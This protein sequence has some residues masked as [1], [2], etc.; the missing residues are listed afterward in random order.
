MSKDLAFLDLESPG[1]L[2]ALVERA[3]RVKPQLLRAYDRYVLRRYDIGKEMRF[4]LEDEMNEREALNLSLHCTPGYAEFQKAPSYSVLKVFLSKMVFVAANKRRLARCLLAR[5]DSPRGQREKRLYAA[6]RM[7]LTVERLY[8]A[9]IL[10]APPQ[11]QANA[12]LHLGHAYALM[13]DI[14]RVACRKPYRRTT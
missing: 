3:V 5:K 10:G 11:V 4:G 2:D 12:M 13:E 7:F 6:R 1:R 14:V 8:N 9:A